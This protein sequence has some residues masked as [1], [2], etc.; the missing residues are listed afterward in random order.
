M[1]RAHYLGR[2]I[3][4][5]DFRFERLVISAIDN[6]P[7]IELYGEDYRRVETNL[8]HQQVRKGDEY[9]EKLNWN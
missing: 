7:I 8:F 5:G 9:M 1:E 2:L 3:G 4:E 6:E